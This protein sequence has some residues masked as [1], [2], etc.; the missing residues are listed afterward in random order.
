VTLALLDG[1]GVGL[2]DDVFVLPREAVRAFLSLPASA[3]GRGSGVVPASGRALP[4][5][6]LREL[7]GRGRPAA[8][9]G[10]VESVVV[11]GF[12]GVELGIAVDHLHGET[13]VMVA[14]ASPLFRGAR[15]VAGCSVL[16]SGRVALVL[17]VAGL[18]HEAR[19]AT[20]ERSAPS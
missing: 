16:G 4:F 15:A 8:P 17:D 12:D 13:R 1:F 5:C 20:R 19:R 10:W 3:A 7:F 14:P 11:L 6:Q 2:D 9:A 18:F